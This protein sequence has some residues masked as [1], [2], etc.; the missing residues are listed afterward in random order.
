MIKHRIVAFESK[1]V[2]TFAV[3]PRLAVLAVY[4]KLCY[5][6][7]VLIGN[8]NNLTLDVVVIALFQRGFAIKT[9]RLAIISIANDGNLV[10][11]FIVTQVL[12]DRFEWNRLDCK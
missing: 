12:H 3:Y 8:V 1:T 5:L 10:G 7:F 6:L 2:Y 9:E 4:P 11:T